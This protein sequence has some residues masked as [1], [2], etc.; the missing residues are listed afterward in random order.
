MI[1][2]PKVIHYFNIRQ[3]K[4]QLFSHS[5]RNSGIWKT[6]SP[7]KTFRRTPE[8]VIMCKETALD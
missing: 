3:E 1:F 5:L 7:F 2:C 8:G 6:K 4:Q